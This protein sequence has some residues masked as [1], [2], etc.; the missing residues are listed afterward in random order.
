MASHP[1]ILA[2]AGALAGLM[3]AP[4][5]A[6]AFP[7]ALT[8]VESRCSQLYAEAQ[9]LNRE[10]ISFQDAAVTADR[11][12]AGAANN[13][14]KVRGFG[15]WEIQISLKKAEQD[16]EREQEARADEDRGLAFSPNHDP[17]IIRLRAS[18]NALKDAQLRL[19]DK[20]GTGGLIASDK[21][22]LDRMAS[23]YRGAA[24][25]SRQKAAELENQAR[26]VDRDRLACLAEAARLRAG[27][28]RGDAG[29]PD[30]ADA[31][32]SLPPEDYRQGYDG[33]VSDASYGPADYG[34]VGYGRGGRDRS[35]RWDN[36]GGRMRGDGGRGRGDGYGNRSRRDGGGRDRGGGRGEGKERGHGKG[37]RDQ[38]SGGCGG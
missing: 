8:L 38:T 3:L 36:D 34:P 30:F 26:A 11:E 1:S 21:N 22:A 7:N 18:I 24:A 20:D 6:E 35:N 32:A 14:N 10:A 25:R 13:A 27:N 23:Q 2:L 4:A 29:P 9:Q 16:L 28:D 17:N 37:G 31:Y 33:P 19:D 5:P 12:A 15:A